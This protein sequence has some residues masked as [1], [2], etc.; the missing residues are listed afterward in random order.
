[1]RRRQRYSRR[2][3]LR[4]LRIRGTSAHPRCGKGSGPCAALQVGA[5]LEHHAC[6]A[7]LVAVP[8]DRTPRGALPVDVLTDG[9]EPT[10]RAV[11]DAL[12]PL[13][14]VVVTCP[15][16]TDPSALRVP[17]GPGWAEGGLKSLDETDTTHP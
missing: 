5:P 8:P 17:I 15:P 9:V 14:V 12:Q 16:R 2:L 1:V 13:Q 6:E 7:A 3:I 10:P 4:H 11:L